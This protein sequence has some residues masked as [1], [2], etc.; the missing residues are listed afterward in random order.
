MACYYNNMEQK[1]E[2]QTCAWKNC[3]ELVQVDV[4]MNGGIFGINCIG[5]CEFHQRVYSK[6]CDLWQKQ[7]KKKGED[8]HDLKNRLYLKD[9]KKFNKINKEIE[10]KALE[11]VK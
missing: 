3:Q 9:R 4:S 1:L 6:E 5:W 10:R 11:L 7:R 8:G 2:T